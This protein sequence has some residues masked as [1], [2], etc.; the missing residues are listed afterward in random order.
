MLSTE[1][2]YQAIQVELNAR[3]KPSKTLRYMMQAFENYRQAKKMG[4]SRAWNK[5]HVVNFQSF[6]LNKDDQDLCRFA[7]HVVTAEAPQMPEEASTFVAELLQ[8]SQPP[9]G[10]LFFQEFTDQNRRYEGAIVSYGRIN[11]KN[12]R[13]RDRLDIILESE[14]IDGVSQGLSR[15]RIFVDPYLGV[16]EPLWQ[17]T[18]D[19]SFHQ[20]SQNLFEHLASL[21]WE[22]ANDSRRI[23]NHWVTDYIDYFGQRQWN[24]KKSYFHIPSGK[25]HRIGMTTDSETTDKP[26]AA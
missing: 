12:K 4:W 11:A 13:F 8:N 25:D 24:M 26:E 21:S 1:Q 18:I 9:M 20:E 2:E 16:K 23:W 3:K 17:G 15:I 6:K 5:Y 22:W 14:V 19:K 7:R 10:F